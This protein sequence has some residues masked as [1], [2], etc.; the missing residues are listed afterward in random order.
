MQGGESATVG[1]LPYGS[2]TLS[3][4]DAPP[5]ATI[6]PNPAVVGPDSPTVTVTVTNPYPNVG[7]FSVT[8][9]VTGA[10]EGYVAGSTFTMSYDC[11]NG[12]DGTLTLADGET[13]TVSGLP[14][15]TT[16]TV[17]EVGIPDPVPGY[18]YGEPV[19][20]PPD[21]T[22][23]VGSTTEPVTVTVENPLVWLPAASADIVND[24]ESGG[25]LVTMRNDGGGEVVFQI[26]V[27]GE[28]FGPTHTVGSEG[29]QTV[30]VPLAEDQRATIAVEAEGFGTVVEDVVQLNCNEPVAAFAV[31][32]AEGGVVVTLTNDGDTPVDLT[33]TK[34][35][36]VVATVTV[37]DTPVEVLVPMDEDETSTITVT[38]GEVP[39]DEQ[40]I[41]YDCTPPDTVPP[42]TV[43]P[44]TVPPGDTI[45]P[46]SV[47]TFEVLGTQ[48]TPL[49]VTGSTVFGMVAL[50]A[51]LILAG[52]SLLGMARRRS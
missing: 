38:N 42:D 37:G 7:S 8:K 49:P 21:G 32:C 29:E 14:V 9:H 22:V 52:A 26:V 5:G 27:D 43:P 17:A 28:N 24:C 35:G 25:A 6:S 12:S 1:D 19:L 33:V 16:C 18:E 41:T 50:A 48:E 31:E 15:G 47:T 13:E 2:Y 11:S 36:E 51:G 40:E 46:A 3:E 20:D 45:P 10:T 23:T 34:D 44:D 30:L 4:V 39:V